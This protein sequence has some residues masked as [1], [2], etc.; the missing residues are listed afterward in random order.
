[1]VKTIYTYEIVANNTAIVTDLESR[2]LAREELQLVKKQG[3]SNAK[4]IQRQYALVKEAQ[5]R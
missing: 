2:S 1:M 4:I 3:Y 5:V